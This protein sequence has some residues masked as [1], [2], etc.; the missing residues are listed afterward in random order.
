M[1][2]EQKLVTRAI[3]GDAEAFGDL[4]ERHVSTIYRYIAYRVN[5]SHDARDMAN[6]VFLK[7]WEALPGYRVRKT[8][9]LGWLYRIAHNL[10][11]DHYRSAHELEPLDD[12]DIWDDDRPVPEWQVIQQSEVERLARAIRQL[13]PDQQHAVILRYVEGLSSGEVANILGRSAGSVRV[14]L[15]RALKSLAGLMAVEEITGG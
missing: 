12:R 11:I 7:A 5:D 13:P 4:Y 2:S 9:F 6:E 1:A 10:V 3:K 14:M 8:P 15:H